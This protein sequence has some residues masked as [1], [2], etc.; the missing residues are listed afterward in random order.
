VNA[1]RRYA[2]LAGEIRQAL[3]IRAA[4]ADNGI[5][6]LGYIKLKALVMQALEDSLTAPFKA[7][8]KNVT[9]PRP[10]MNRLPSHLPL[11]SWNT[12]N[13]LAILSA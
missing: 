13:S 3:T 8:G 5:S 10:K 6:D 12:W 1:L 4:F 7:E 9:T 11:I 2:I